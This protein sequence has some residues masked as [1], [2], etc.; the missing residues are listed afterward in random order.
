[1]TS[2]DIHQLDSQYKP[3]PSFADWRKCN[4]D[5]VTLD[6]HMTALRDVRAKAD[7]II[8]DGL[9]ALHAQ[10]RDQV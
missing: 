5:T 10:A 4:V 6:N 8:G 1:M 7:R 3:F 9:N 2:L